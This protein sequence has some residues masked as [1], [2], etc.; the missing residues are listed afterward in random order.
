M[1]TTIAMLVLTACAAPAAMTRSSLPSFAGPWEGMVSKGGSRAPA[2]FR[3]APREDG[4]TGFFWGRTLTPI[5]LSNVQLGRS[6]HF[7]V[8]ELGVF[9]GTAD[10]DSMEGTFRDGTSGEGSF[11]LEKRPD[12]QDPLS[13]M[14]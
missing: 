1:K 4:Y 3:F 13:V 6:V 5:E 11:R 7:E 9:D 14:F 8:P 12:P 2:E 10:G